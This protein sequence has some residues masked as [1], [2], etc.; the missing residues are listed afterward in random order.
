MAYDPFDELTLL[1]DEAVARLASTR[2]TF[3]EREALMD[4][5][6]AGYEVS[7]QSNPRFV[8]AQE[9]GKQPGHWRLS[10][11]TLANNRLLNDLLTDAWDGYNLDAHLAEL[12]VE[13]A[14]EQEEQEK[15]ASEHGESEEHKKRPHHVYCPLDL[16]LTLN[17]QGRLE[18]V[19]QERNITIP[20]H[21]K[22]ALDALAKQLLTRWRQV[23]ISDTTGSAEAA[24]PPWTLRTIM[25]ELSELGWQDAETRNAHLYVRAWLLGWP[26]VV[27]VGQ[28]Y[29]L[30]A[31]TLPQE[32]QRSRLRVLPVYMPR[33]KESATG[34]AGNEYHV[35]E[36]QRTL[37]ERGDEQVMIDGEAT[38]VRAVWSQRLRTA[39]LLQGFLPIPARARVALLPPAPGEQVRS[40]L[41]GI[42]YDDNTHFWLWLDRENSYFYGPVLA[43]KLAWQAAGDIIHIIWEESTVVLRITGHDDEIEN[44]ES[45][46]S[47]SC[48]V[49]WASP[50]APR[51]RTSSRL[52]QKDCPSQRSSRLCANASSMTC[53]AEPF[54]HSSREAASC[55]ASNA[56]SPPQIATWERDNCDTPLLRHSSC[57]HNRKRRVLNTTR[58]REYERY[59]RDWR[60]LW[61]NFIVYGYK[62]SRCATYPHCPSH[63]FFPKERQAEIRAGHKTASGSVQSRGQLHRVAR[64]GVSPR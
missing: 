36:R 37:R 59:E 26:A 29:W 16:R 18:A 9:H 21:I 5:W 15:Q 10:S 24:I 55:S 45:M 43:D 11:H 25:N 20:P 39:H 54:T 28:D 30:P 53:I 62:K 23:G 32:V 46:P 17:A 22:A 35:A 14:R 3:T 50:T 44:E 63:H 2:R 51:Y 48:A 4:I 6:N 47:R 61:N 41:Q 38:E 27:R 8:L 33:L 19:G 58:R 60:R 49:V 64:C 56:G 12:D 57:K 1:K 42:W 40:I 13:A 31:D 34:E 7:I 52:I